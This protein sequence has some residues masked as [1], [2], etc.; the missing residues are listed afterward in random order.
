MSAPDNPCTKSVGKLPKTVVH[1]SFLQRPAYIV[2]G[3]NDDL[4]KINLKMLWNHRVR[5]IR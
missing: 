5:K 3:Q 1:A 4:G 2:F